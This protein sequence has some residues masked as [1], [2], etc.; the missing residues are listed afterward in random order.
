MINKVFRPVKGADGDPR[1]GLGPEAGARQ[2]PTVVLV[3]AAN[4]GKSSLFNRLIGENR[5]MVTATPGTTRDLLAG[6]RRGR[7]GEVR[8]VDTP[9]AGGR[10]LDDL[11]ARADLVL[12]V[13]D[14]RQGCT[15]ADRAWAA[16]LRRRGRRFLVVVNKAEGAAA[17][18]ARNE[19]F[20]I[21][22]AEPIAVSAT[23]GSG[24]EVLRAALAPFL[25]REAAAAEDCGA[26]LTLALVGRPNAGKSTLSNLL[27]G[28]PRSAVEETPG[29][30]RDVVEGWTRA[31]DRW[32]QIL[33]TAG[34]E[35]KFRDPLLQLAARQTQWRLRECDVAALVVDTGQKV[36]QA[37][38]IYLRKIHDLGKPV[39]IVGNK[40]DRLTGPAGGLVR[41]W[42]SRFAH[43]GKP[44]IVLVSA[45]TGRGCDRLFPTARRLARCSARRIPTRSLHR[46]LEEIRLE[47]DT[48]RRVVRHA[49]Q[50]GIRP[51]H[52]LFLHASSQIPA[53]Y[54]AF[55]RNR[56]QRRF[57]LESV[58]VRVQIRRQKPGA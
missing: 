46:F 20:S 29:T 54:R 57:G 16:R 22:P 38:R 55:L 7:A 49:I 27:L 28:Q 36:G 12:L 21:A 25:D 17:E 44:P 6:R 8:F 51:P 50:V 31:G 24:I 32:Y 10:L 14:G 19:F 56:L 52:F 1:I 15:P 4:A 41:E 45:L 48:G 53:G 3:G 43:G 5:A 35:R 30:T 9:M 47:S 18:S 42:R 11:V 26:F 23:Q 33:D 39:I 37:D 40:V 2:I 13:T 34:R 58:P